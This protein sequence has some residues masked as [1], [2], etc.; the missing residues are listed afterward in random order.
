MAIVLWIAPSVLI[1][2]QEHAGFRH[3]ESA[4]AKVP[5]QHS[6][7]EIAAKEFGLNLETWSGLTRMGHAV[8]TWRMK[9]IPERRIILFDF[10]YRRSLA[11]NKAQELLK[12]G[13]DAD[14]EEIRFLRIYLGDGAMRP[15]LLKHEKSEAHLAHE[16]PGKPPLAG[17]GQRPAEPVVKDIKLCRINWDGPKE[18]TIPSPVPLPGGGFDSHEGHRGHSSGGITRDHGNSRHEDHRRG[19]GGGG[20]SQGHE[21]SHR[22][23]SAGGPDDARHGPGAS[24]SEGAQHNSSHGQSLSIAPATSAGASHVH[25]AKGGSNAMSSP[26]HNS[27]P[28][29]LH[30]DLAHPQP[31][32]GRSYERPVAGFSKNHAHVPSL[33]NSPAKAGQEGDHRLH[34]SSD[35][36]AI[37]D[38]GV[39]QISH[40][41]S[42]PQGSFQRH[43]RH[44]QAT[45]DPGLPHHAVA[46]G[47]P[48]SNFPSA[49]HES[50][51]GH[52]AVDDH[53]ERHKSLAARQTN[54]APADIAASHVHH[55]DHSTHQ[56]QDIER[57]AKEN[58]SP[59]SD[60]DQK[61]NIPPWP[62]KGAVL[63]ASVAYAGALWK[64]RKVGPQ[65]RNSQRRK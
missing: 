64:R 9:P 8:A 5:S 53:Q 32:Y 52:R 31:V 4:M 62:W 36:S 55:N 38:H 16:H 57:P 56:K 37:V 44:S 28:A 1:F 50:V 65:F 2:A 54:G 45:Q 15:I 30:G 60:V 29:S 49:V 12:A 42:S 63:F 25:A 61:G 20:P 7:D 14:C 6:D 22:Q 3:G 13:E 51:F 10:S 19:S 46:H 33:M 34:S 59:G 18:P 17:E 26:R 48:D 47:T 41:A 27:E 40:E 11:L 23:G 21:N 58:L 43:A 39:H 35:Y 24:R